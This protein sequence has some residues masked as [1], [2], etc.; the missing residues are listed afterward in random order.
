V[1]AN[2][3]NQAWLRS[4]VVTLITFDLKGAFNGVNRVSLDSQLQSKGI[5]TIVRR[6]I[7]S[8]MEDRYASI[9]FDDF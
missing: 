6:W 1:L 4:K 2:A 9:A 8:F 5:P 7:Y 3:I